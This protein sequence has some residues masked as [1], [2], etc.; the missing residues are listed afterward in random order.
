MV[1][2]INTQHFVVFSSVTAFTVLPQEN[3]SVKVN[4]V[5]VPEAD[6]MAT[7]GVIHFVNQLLYPEGKTF[8]LSAPS[9]S[10]K[11]VKL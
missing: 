2:S 10:H 1:V 9:L 4:S 7:N 11:S 5:Q 3:D 8:I 6:I